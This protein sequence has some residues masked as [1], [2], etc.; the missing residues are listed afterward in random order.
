VSAFIDALTGIYNRG[1]FMTNAEAQ[2]MRSR[3]N[4][5][6]CA[7]IMMDLDLFKQVN[8]TYGHLAG[9]AVLKTV[10]Q[11]VKRTLRAYDLFARYGGEEFIMMIAELDY[12]RVIQLVERI[13]ARIEKTPCVYESLKLTITCSFGVA[14]IEGTKNLTEMIKNADSAL[15]KAKESGRNCVSFFTHLTN[16]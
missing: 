10:A 12:E 15:Y 13:R 7:V 3:R 6:N 8:D 4:M 5:T 16:T 1:Y 11:E 9:D 2:Y 14:S